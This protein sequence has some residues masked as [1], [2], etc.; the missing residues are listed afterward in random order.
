MS[1]KCRHTYV[2]KPEGWTLW[3]C[4]HC[5]GKFVLRK[6]GVTTK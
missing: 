6:V 2:Y 5:D 4:R 1:E 3:I